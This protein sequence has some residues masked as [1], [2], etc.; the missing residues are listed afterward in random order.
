[1]KKKLI[2]ITL[3]FAMLLSIGVSAMNPQI[4]R[5][6][7]NEDGAVDINDA[8]EILKYLAGLDGVIKDSPYYDLGMPADVTTLTDVTTPTDVTEPTDVTAPADVTASADVTTPA[9]VTAPP[10]PFEPA[11][12]SE[13]QL[14]VS[15]IGAGWNLGNT[16]DA[17]WNE[18][19][20]WAVPTIQNIET[21]W[22]NPVTAKEMIDFVKEAGFNTVRIPVTWYIFTGESPDYIISEEWMDRVQT[23]VDYVMDNDMFCIINIHHDDYRTFGNWENGWFRLYHGEEDRPLNDEEKS[24]MHNRFAMLWTQIAERFEDYD[25]RLIFEGINEPRTIRGYSTL[26][27]CAEQTGFLNELLQ[28]FV[29]TVR[30]GGGNNP[31]RFLMVAPYFAGFNLH[32]GLD[33]Q[34]GRFLNRE[35]G[36]LFI[37]D[38]RDRLIVSLHFYEPWGFVSA[39][40]TSEWHFYHYDVAA[41]AHNMGLLRR[42]VNEFTSRGIAVI[43]GETGAITRTLP[44]GTS[45]EGERVKWAEHYVSVMRELGV[46]TI[47]WDDG[48]DFRLLNRNAIEWFYPDLAAALVAAAG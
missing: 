1:M 24:Q 31:D 7:V 4:L 42:T 27:E 2:S 21:L 26:G 25:E 36:Q 38:E 6:D 18:S 5:G 34:I 8:L 15:Q 43:M 29:D 39:P 33:E 40:D 45:N 10:L 12:L 44:D 22:G 3:V 17:H 28:T 47:I 41:A 9:D 37:N 32:S 20:P 19:L 14:F 16:L 48:G 46:P 13:S 35:T 30:A 23:V 11:E